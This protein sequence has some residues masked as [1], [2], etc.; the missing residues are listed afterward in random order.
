[1]LAALPPDI[2]SDTKSKVIL[3]FF[4]RSAGSVGI[5][6][7]SM[8]A[9]DIPALIT[10]IA[11]AVSGNNKGSDPELK[12]LLQKLTDNNTTQQNEQLKTLVTSVQT[13]AEEIKKIK[14]GEGSGGDTKKRGKVI[15]IDQDKKIHEYED[16]QPIIVEHNAATE[17]PLEMI[18]EENRHAEEMAKVNEQEKF[19][20]DIVGTPQDAMVNIG[21]GLAR[22]AERQAADGEGEGAVVKKAKGES[23]KCPDCKNEIPIFP[24][25]A[26]PVECPNCGQ[27]LYWKKDVK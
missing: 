9:G 12:A 2:D 22:N 8:G 24:E 18:H 20:K 23:I 10:A 25:T 11:N 6:G 16:G 26:S 21:E 14:L 5:T 27:T 13:M 7:G 4:Q 3:G 1:M 15:V 17:K 19:H